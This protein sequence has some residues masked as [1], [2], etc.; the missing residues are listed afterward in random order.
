VQHGGL[1]NES[2]RSVGE[3]DGATPYEKWIGRKPNLEHLRILFGSEAFVNVPKQHVTKLGVRVKKMVL[4][5]YESISSNYQVY[6]PVMRKVTVLRDVVFHEEIGKIMLPANNDS[7]EEM[8]L[9]KIE[10]EV[11]PACEEKEDR[12]EEEDDEVFLPAENGAANQRQEVALPVP[13]GGNIG[14]NLRDRGSMK[15]PSRSRR[16]S[17]SMKFPQRLKK[18]SRVKTP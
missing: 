1:F 7:H 18:Q 8:I 3:R 12:E 11:V 15:R 13:R 6:D 9:P 16:M 2:S 10:E 5:G 17:S 4:F 14:P